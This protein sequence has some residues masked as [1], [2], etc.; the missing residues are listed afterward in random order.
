M[1]HVHCRQRDVSN[2]FNKFSSYVLGVQQLG[3]GACG[4]NPA[5]QHQTALQAPLPPQAAR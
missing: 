2:L 1:D 3:S 4:E 5:I